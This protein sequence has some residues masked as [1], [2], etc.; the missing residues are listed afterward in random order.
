MAKKIK[1]ITSYLD[2]K[3]GEIYIED[4]HKAEELKRLGRA[5]ILEDL[6][7]PKKKIMRPRRKR[8]YKTK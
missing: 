8:T 4:D 1:L 6:N 7:K 5:E 3:P 2:R